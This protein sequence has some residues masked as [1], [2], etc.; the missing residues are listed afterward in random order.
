VR[1]AERLTDQ[2]VMELY[3]LQTVGLVTTNLKY[4]GSTDIKQQI[5][6]DSSFAKS[7]KFLFFPPIMIY[8]A[9]SWIADM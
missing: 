8:S 1:Q 9:A 5:P 3:T 2:Q 7:D 4:T 6:S